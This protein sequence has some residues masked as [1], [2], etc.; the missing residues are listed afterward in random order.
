MIVENSVNEI[1]VIDKSE[2]SGTGLT[3]TQKR[4]EFSYPGKHNLDIKK[5]DST[6]KAALKIDL[7]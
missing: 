5:N 3:N 6:F 1:E 4:L 2:S 7:S